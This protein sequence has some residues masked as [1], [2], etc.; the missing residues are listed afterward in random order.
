M[1]DGCA[2]GYALPGDDKVCRVCRAVAGAQVDADISQPFHSFCITQ[3]AYIRHG[4]LRGGRTLTR[5]QQDLAAGG[6]HYARPGQLVGNSIALAD[7]PGL[8]AALRQST[9]SFSQAHTGDFR[10]GTVYIFE[11]RI[12]IL[13]LVAQIGQNIRHHLP[14]HRRGHLTAGNVDAGF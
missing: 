2:G 9:L 1:F 10:N 6:Y 5:V 11:L 4:L 8:E 13:R 12:R 14:H 3:A 7:Y